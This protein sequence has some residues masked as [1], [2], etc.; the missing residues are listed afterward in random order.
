MHEIPSYI[1][2]YYSEGSDILKNVCSYPDEVAE[3]FLSNL[4]ESGKRTWLHPGYLEERRRVEA[5]LHEQFMRENKKPY[6]KNPRYFV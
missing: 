1:T 3:A 5:W 6:L 2:H 4:K